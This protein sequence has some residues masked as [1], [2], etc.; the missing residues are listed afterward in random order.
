MQKEISTNLK[1][2]ENLWKAIKI[3]A[4]QDGKT[5]KDL[6]LQ[7]IQHV[8]NPVGLPQKNKSPQNF[9]MKFSGKVSLPITD[10]SVKHDQYLYKK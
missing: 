3:K 6:I 9:L 2:P 1:I 7:G 5:M 10:G 4:A 8:L